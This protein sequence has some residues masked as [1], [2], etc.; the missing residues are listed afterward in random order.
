MYRITEN[1]RIQRSADLIKDALITCLQEK[2]FDDITV[3][4]IQRISG[5]SRATFYRIFDNTTDV[6]LYYC[7]LLTASITAQT[8]HIIFENHKDFLLF[9]FRAMMDNHVF[10]EAVFRSGYEDILLNTLLDY[11]M[12]QHAEHVSPDTPV[13]E[14]DYIISGIC[15]YLIGIMKIWLKHGKQESPE[16][17]YQIIENLSQLIV[18]T[19]FKSPE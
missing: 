18:A 5:V 4:D 2:D 8:E 15:G 6:L 16:E 3:S 17:L 13:K 14:M 19:Y 7:E 12:K 10:V 11:T 1:K 9:I